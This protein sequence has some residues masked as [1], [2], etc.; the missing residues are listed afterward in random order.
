MGFPLYRAERVISNISRVVRLL[1]SCFS[2]YSHYFFITRSAFRHST[3]T[4]ANFYHYIDTI[5]FY[6]FVYPLRSFGFRSRDLA[7]VVAR[8]KSWMSPKRVRRVTI[9]QNKFRQITSLLPYFV[10]YQASSMEHKS[11]PFK[12]LSFNYNSF[13]WFFPAHCSG[14]YF[15]FSTFCVIANFV[16]SLSACFLVYVSI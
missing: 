8:G 15:E 13:V 5:D 4:Q 12:H 2:P 16:L 3:S 10:T 14:V 11:T 1:Y 7:S 6:F 9:I